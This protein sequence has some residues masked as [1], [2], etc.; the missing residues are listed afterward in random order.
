M[1]ASVS[2]GVAGLAAWVVGGALLVTACDGP[3]GGTGGVDCAKVPTAPACKPD[4]SGGGQDIII[5]GDDA[6]SNPGDTASCS[7][8]A[9]MCNGNVPR[10]CQ[11]S[12]WVDLAACSAGQTC[13]N[14]I[15]EEQQ[16]DCCVGMEC[17]TDC[18]VSCGTCTGDT[19]CVEGSCE[20]NTTCVPECTGRVCGDDGCG[21]SCGACGPGKSCQNGICLNNQTCSCNGAV[22]GEDNCGNSCGECDVGDTCEA[23]ECVPGGSTGSDSCT[24]LVDCIFSDTGCSQ[25]ED[26]TQ[27]QECADTCYGQG[28]AT[29]QGELDAYIGCAG[30][31]ADDA[32]FAQN[33]SDEQA[34]CFFDKSGPGSCFDILDCFDTCPETDDGTCAIACYEASNTA[35]QAALLGLNNCLD[36]ECPDAT[37][38]NDPCYDTAIAGV[39]ANF[40]SACQNN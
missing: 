11:N 8:G 12:Q 13:T 21:H 4:T 38:P 33:C 32:C 19:T 23:G 24:D 35:A 6:T 7:T 17:G 10:Q 37:D 2:V 14:G 26:D 27:F 9:R 16:G 22:C 1:R 20:P 3:G 39:C 31:C 40:V 5:G 30:N 18:G 15:C 28:S 29:A 36:A 34:A 25:F